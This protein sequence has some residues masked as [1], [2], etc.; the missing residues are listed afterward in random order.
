MALL[1]LLGQ[2]TVPNVPGEDAQG[3]RESGVVGVMRLKALW[4]A[5]IVNIK[6]RMG[7]MVTGR[8]YGSYWEYPMI[9]RARGCLWNMKMRGEK[10]SWTEWWLS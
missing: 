2:G 3:T 4:L 9:Q 8:D 5:A 1:A 10:Y 6:F 7:Y